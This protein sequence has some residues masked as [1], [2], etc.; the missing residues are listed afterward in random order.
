MKPAA[1][2]RSRAYA[3]A[4]HD[5]HAHQ[6]DEH[7]ARNLSGTAMASGYGSAFPGRAED[8]WGI[9]VPGTGGRIVW[10]RLSW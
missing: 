8:G 2:T 10:A 7:P 4:E 5:K 9:Q 1:D 3:R 6:P